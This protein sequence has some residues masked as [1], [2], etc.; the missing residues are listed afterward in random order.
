[1]ISLKA[2]KH[3]TVYRK[4]GSM[5]ENKAKAS[6]TTN[7]LNTASTTTFYCTKLL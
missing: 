5:S 6:E 3:I 7:E 1:L 2:D 4:L